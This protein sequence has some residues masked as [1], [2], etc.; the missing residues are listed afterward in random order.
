MMLG[1]PPPP[2]YLEG[3]DAELGQ[4]SGLRGANLLAHT[5]HLHILHDLNRTLVDLG[6]DVEDLWREGSAW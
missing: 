6:G 5:A 3:L 4:Q 2:T 1:R